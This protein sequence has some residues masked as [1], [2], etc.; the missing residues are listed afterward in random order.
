L[1]QGTQSFAVRKSASP[2]GLARPLPAP[3]KRGL[4][5]VRKPQVAAKRPASAGPVKRIAT[6]VPAA[7]KVKANEGDWA[8]F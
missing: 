6:S 8:A 5:P 3:V 7:A 1:G 4:A 2:A